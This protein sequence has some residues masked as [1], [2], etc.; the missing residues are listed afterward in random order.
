MNLTDEEITRIVRNYERRLKVDRQRY[1][2]VKDDPE[3][4][5]KNRARA[6]EYYQMNK[7]KKKQQYEENKDIVK[8]KNLLKYWQKNNK[9]VSGIKDK[10]PEKYKILTERGL[11]VESPES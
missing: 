2:K 7:E 5:K 11:I 3:F 1:M 6:N 10:H 4:I 8:A 9:D